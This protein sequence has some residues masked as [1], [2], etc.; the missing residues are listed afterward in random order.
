M[1]AENSEGNTEQ[2]VGAERLL[3]EAARS[4]QGARRRLASLVDLFLPDAMRLSDYQRVTV[5]RFIARLVAAV[6]GDVR[7]RL[8]SEHGMRFSPE[9]IAALGSARVAI[10]LPVLE[11]ARALHDVELVS[12]LLARVEEQRVTDGLRRNA[13]ANG[14]VSTLIEALLAD[15]DPALSAAAMSLLI[16]ESRRYYIFEESVLP[17]TDL[18]ADIQYRLVWWVAAALRDYMTRLH[19]ADSVQVDAALMDVAAAI[20]AGHDEGETL[21]ASAMHL[22]R[23]LGERGW[24]DDQVLKAACVEGRLALLIAI[25]ASRA[26]L[27]FEATRDM[28]L[29]PHGDRLILLLKALNVSR[30]TAAAILLAMGPGDDGFAEAM[31][32]Y[33]M[34]D[35]EQAMEAIRPWQVDAGYRA[36]IAGLAAGLAE[37]GDGWAA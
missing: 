8:V 27:D 36:A 16:A 23:L 5:R 28:I 21:E 13:D 25:L 17:R 33:D 20:L 22:A 14:E 29:P 4:A 34:L 7:Q 18:P 31:M 12:L 3:A 6:E 30:E 32:A 9:L 37:R 19:G 1:F 2:P 26:G 15:A 11:R 35:P 10:A 24:L